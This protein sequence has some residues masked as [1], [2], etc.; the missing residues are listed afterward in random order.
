M[1]TETT[2]QTPQDGQEAPEGA[3]APLEATEPAE[4]QQDHQQ[5]GQDEDD[6]DDEHPA[7]E[8]KR[9]RLRLREAEATRDQLAAQV[10]AMQRAEAERIAAATVIQP[11]SIWAAGTTVADVLDDDGNVDPEKVKAATITAAESLGLA[12]TKSGAFSPYAGRVPQSRPRGGMADVIR[13]E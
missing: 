9:Y 8:A 1:S 11:A 4:D 7:A 13:G 6:N 2:T 12:R 10:E 5:D 3:Q